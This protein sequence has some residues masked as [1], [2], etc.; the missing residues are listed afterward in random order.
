M[1]GERSWADGG[2]GKLRSGSDGDLRVQPQ[3]GNVSLVWKPQFSWAF[4]ATI[5]GMVEGGERT[6]AGVSQAYLT[7]RP[8][9][10]SKLAFSARAGLMW[11]PISVEHEGADWHVKDSI[12]PSAI[13]SWIGE[14]V[15]PLAA[16]ATLA[17]SVGEH[18]LRATAALIAANDTAGTLLTFRGWALHDRTTLAFSRQPLPPLGEF[19]GLQAPYTHPLLDVHRG[20]GRRIGYY[21]KL[22][23]QPPVPVHIEIFRY[24][25]GAYPEDVTAIGPEWGWRTRFNHLGLIA[26]L[27]S[28]TELKSQALE[29]ST[30]MGLPMAGRR[31]VDERFRAA[32]LMLDHKAGKMT[33]AVR[34]DL[35]DTRNR[36]SI[37]SDEYDEHGWS[38]MLSIKRDWS[39]VSGLLEFL[40]VWSK[41]PAREYFGEDE[42]QPQTQ[43]QA[44][45]RI[46]W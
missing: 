6:Q 42:R 19:T 18:K 26:D 11:P 41:T 5:V 12:T 43:L 34:T 13:N 25:N 44:E 1:D 15:K 45:V 7:F 38:G 21:A 9:R 17:T 32:Y 37:W 8:M 22:A 40:H 36:G 3:L 14:E 39:H 31:W 16:E 20:F 30:R 35:F 4:G 23:W 24:D 28:G 10:S 46:H 33:F 27:G 2:F 29:G